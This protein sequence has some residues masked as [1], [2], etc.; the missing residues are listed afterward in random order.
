MI[1]PIEYIQNGYL[2]FSTYNKMYGF[3]KA[4]SIMFKYVLHI[5]KAYFLEVDLIPPRTAPVAKIPLDIRYYSQDFDI[6]SWEFKNK[7]FDIRGEYGLCQF[8]ERLSN[9]SIFV[10]AYHDGNLAGFYWGSFPPVRDAGYKLNSDCVYGL[11][12]FVFEECRGKG[13]HPVLHYALQSNLKE[14]HPEIKRLVS[15]VATWNKKSY[16]GNLFAGCK[17][18]KLDLSIVFLGFH[19]KFT[20]KEY[21]VLAENHEE[22]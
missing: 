22:I 5:E 11:D 7:I 2:K 10:C 19:K 13:V 3:I 6:D 9:G 12:C 8:K 21:P 16:R 15:H 1:K 20:L 18:T 4:I 14:Q 17:I